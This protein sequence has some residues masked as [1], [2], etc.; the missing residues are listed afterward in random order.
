MAVQVSISQ[1]PEG[2]LEVMVYTDAP[3]SPDLVDDLVNRAVAL[4]RGAYDTIVVR[5]PE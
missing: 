2:A 4:W 1:D 5:E 3:Y